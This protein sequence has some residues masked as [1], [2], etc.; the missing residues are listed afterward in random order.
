MKN[1][2]L[3]CAVALFTACQQ[4]KQE[5]PDTIAVAAPG[6]IVKPLMEDDAPFRNSAGI[7]IGIRLKSSL[8]RGPSLIIKYRC[9]LHANTWKRLL[10]KPIALLLPPMM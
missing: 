2:L 6:D 1:V 5:E 4:Q 7:L 3:A 9:L 10:E 8:F